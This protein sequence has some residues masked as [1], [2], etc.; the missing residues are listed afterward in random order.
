M[1]LQFC[2]PPR[3]GKQLD[4]CLYGLITAMV[5]MRSTS[6]LH[7]RSREKNAESLATFITSIKLKMSFLPTYVC[8][9]E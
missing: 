1:E 2:R 7:Y 8:E 5:I 4:D 3:P 9:K 6:M